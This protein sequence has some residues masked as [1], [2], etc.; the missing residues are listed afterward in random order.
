[1]RPAG[2]LAAPPGGPLAACCFARRT[3]RTL[4]VATEPAARCTTH[5]RADTA[6]R[7]GASVR[8]GALVGAVAHRLGVEVV[9]E[10]GVSRAGQDAPALAL[11]LQPVGQELPVQRR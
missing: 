6:A 9:A 1:M 3:D 4:H 11:L 8:A 5:G 2:G 7:R 10:L